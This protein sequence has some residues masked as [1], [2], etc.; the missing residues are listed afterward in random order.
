[1]GDVANVSDHSFV[2]ERIIETT[3]HGRF[4]T[5]PPAT[6]GPAPLLVGFHGYA[7]NAETQLERL[8]AIPGSNRWLVV[9]IQAL[10]RFYQRR[11]DLVVASWMT[12][13]DREAAIADNILYVRRCIDA[14]S[15]EQATLPTIVFAGFSQGVGMA[16]RA[17]VNEDQRVAG[18]IAVGGDIPPEIEPVSLERVSAALICQGT[19]DEWYTETLFA[20][21]EQRLRQSSVSVRALRLKGGH[22]WSGDLLAAAAQFLQE[23]HPV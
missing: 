3:V 21:D 20:S 22:E 19:S 1:V 5:V 14:V 7:E 4:L 13:Q 15:A 18:V 8:T 2:T 9:S 6:P 10:H 16:F 12:R 17:A 23:R 11:T